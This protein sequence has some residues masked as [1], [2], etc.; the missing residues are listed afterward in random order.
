MLLH[1]LSRLPVHQFA[2]GAEYDGRIIS[3]QKYGCFVELFE[4]FV[5]GLLPI[6]ALEEF[7]TGRGVLRERDQAIVVSRGGG[8]RG[9][10]GG[11]RSHGAKPRQ[12]EWHLGDKVR[13]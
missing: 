10:A 9:A 13:V 1:E 5:D 2:L 4:V 12:L 3:V 8:A 6:G 7:A 11:R